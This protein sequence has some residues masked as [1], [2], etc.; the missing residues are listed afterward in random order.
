MKT[1]DKKRASTSV[2]TVQLDG[3]LKK[4]A[5]VL[6]RSLGISLSAAIRLF[7]ECSISANGF[8]FPV[9][10]EKDKDIEN[11][12]SALEKL[13]ADSQKNGLSNM[14]LEEINEEIDAYRKGI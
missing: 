13:S 5:T 10:L 14:S 9:T 3:E 4:Q 11:A 2:I 7:L 6:F 8:P 1:A 12:C